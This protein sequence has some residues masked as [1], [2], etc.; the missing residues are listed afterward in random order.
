MPHVVV[1][2]TELLV[3]QFFS[4]PTIDELREIEISIEKFLT[5]WPWPL[6]YDLDLD[7]LP[8][9]LHTNVQVRMSVCSAV[10]D[11]QSGIKRVISTYV[12]QNQS[13]PA[14]LH[15]ACLLGGVVHYVYYSNPF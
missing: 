5:S 8:L 1:F 14:E 10:T 4:S 7:I 9:D 11:R 2:L 12:K 3:S 6:T 15:V 13:D